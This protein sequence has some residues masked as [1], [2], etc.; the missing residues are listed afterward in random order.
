MIRIWTTRP[1]CGA[2]SS[3]LTSISRRSAIWTSVPPRCPNIDDLVLEWVTSADFDRMLTETVV[4]TYPEHEREWFMG[5][6][7]GLVG[8]WVD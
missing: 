4:Q 3:W 6:F 2:I 7:R 1:S 8:L 5:H